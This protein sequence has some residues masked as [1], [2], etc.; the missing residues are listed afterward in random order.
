MKNLKIL[1][2]AFLMIL[3][4][5]A[6][7][8]HQLYANVDG[9]ILPYGTKLHMIMGHD[10]KSNLIAQGDMFEASLFNDIFVNNKLVLPSNTIF[11]GRVVGVNYSRK[12]S[13]PASVYLTLDHL[14]TKQ[15]TQLPLRAGVSSISEYII[16]TNGAITTNGS[17]FN[18]V[19]KDAK[20]STKYLKNSINWGKN[21]SKT[22]FNGAEYIFVPIGAIGGSIACAGSTI[23]NTFADLFRNGDEIII[24]KNDTFD[25]IILKDL[26]IPS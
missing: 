19:K 21:T 24:K 1:F 5:K 2:I 20:N 14:I 10:V 3:F 8:A 16:K 22:I 17:Y 12:L 18:A 7:A 23:F 25:I 9:I 4:N 13:R 26:K 11:R 15:G 6:F